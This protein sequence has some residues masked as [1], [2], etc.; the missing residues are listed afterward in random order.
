MNS[1]AQLALSYITKSPT[2]AGHV[3]SSMP[4]VASAAFV[5][6]IP[7]KY[8]VKLFANLLPFA[9][10]RI[11]RVLDDHTAAAIVEDLDFDKSSAIVRQMDRK[12]RD[13]FLSKLSKRTRI[14]LKKSLYFSPGT[15]G[16]HMTQSVAT[17][18]QTDT[19]AKALDTIKN[20]DHSHIDAVFVLNDSGKL[21]GIVSSAAALRYPETTRLIDIVDTSCGQV[22]AYNK[23]EAITDPELWHNF[24]YL[25]VVDR[26]RE[27]I[28][29]ISRKA[30]LSGKSANPTLVDPRAQSVPGSVLAALATTST[31]LLDLMSTAVVGIE[32]TGDRDES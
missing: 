31:G 22:S 26:K 12:D 30:L 2:S 16:A 32:K 6:Q 17:L 25:P 1:S 7:I 10:V 24:I 5:E 28:G 9:A 15:V 14:S 20:Y 27:V 8:A 21:I 4:H 11:I 29:A 19:V 18:L 23:L 3:L 13:Q